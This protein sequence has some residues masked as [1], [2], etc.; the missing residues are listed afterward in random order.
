[1][2][3]Q[4]II[5]QLP[6]KQIR[7]GNTLHEI[8][9]K[10]FGGKTYEEI[11]SLV[12]G[13]IGTYVIP[14][15]SNSKGGYDSVVKSEE[16]TVTTTKSILNDLTN[17]DT[18]DYKL[19]DIVLMEELSDGS[20]VFDRWVSEVNGDTIKLTVLETQVAK[21]HHNIAT[22]TGNAI[23]NVTTTNTK[24]T[25]PTVGASITVLDGSSAPTVV[26]S[27]S[28]DNNGKHNLTLVSTSGS[29]SVGHS[30]TIT[31]HSH[32]VSITPINFV[33]DTIDVYT[34]LSASKYTPHT[35]TSTSVASV[36]V[37]ASTLVYANGK[38]VTDTFVKTLKDSTSTTGDKE[39]TTK[40]NTVGL[41]TNT[42]AST[43]TVGDIVKT[44]T[45]G[46]HSHT[47]SVETNSDIVTSASVAATV[48]T[49]VSL[50]YVAPTVQKTVVTY[51]STSTTSVV[52]S[53][54]TS[55]S[56]SNFTNNWQVTKDGIL[57]LSFAAAL[58]GVSVSS[59]TASVI[60]TL[61]QTTASQS[62]GSANVTTSSASQSIKTG[63]VSSSGTTSTNGGHTHGFSHTHTIVSHTHTI[64]SHSHSYVKS[65]ADATGKAYTSLST[66]NYVPHTHGSVVTVLS[67]VVDGD[68]FTYLA[69]GE[70]A[71]VIKTLKSSAQ[72][73]STTS[74]GAS[75]DTK[76]VKLTGD[77]TF[78]GLTVAT[79]TLSTT[80]V[81]PAVEGTE[82]AIASVTTVSGSFVTSVDSKTSGNIGGEY[83][84]E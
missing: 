13:A 17:T 9:A 47:I 43:D 20:K 46:S 84:K 30:H 57:E 52:T 49:D 10:Y 1:M 77:I 62:A 6:I 75:T 63:K 45:S 55:V 82:Y 60:S 76:Y 25:I 21:H 74:D 3:E 22:E 56:T 38:G 35:H 4:L 68:E 66:D 24:V 33:E 27:V 79:K 72:S 11:V 78:P 59:S 12:Q 61:S 41:T 31:S 42:Q 70:T 8:D 51:V 7:V 40:G 48:I 64:A 34:S 36:Q 53:V 81:K 73:L 28:H 19:G 39:L 44:T 80:T 54:S 65:V 50:N 15:S 71:T 23:T 32:S 26:T 5:S 18:A 83:V 69:S 58:T 67:N 37:D 2:D 14:I 29:G 16:T